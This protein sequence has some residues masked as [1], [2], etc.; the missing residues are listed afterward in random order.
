MLEIPK[1]DQFQTIE[2]VIR[3]EI[4]VKS[5][6]FIA[7]ALPIANLED[8]NDSL[9]II[10]QEFFDATHNCYAYRLGQ[11]A[12]IYKFS[13]DGEPNGSAGKPILYTISKFDFTNILVVV[14]RYY[15]GTKLGV[16]GLVRAYSDS[17][18]E[19]LKIAIPKIIFIS[20]NYK[21]KCSYQDVSLVKRLITDFAI[22]HNEQYTDVVEFDIEIPKSLCNYFENFIFEKSNGKIIAQKN[23]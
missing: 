12:D 7:T 23:I 19:S 18:E 6:K 3:T 11:F 22:K 14:T 17:T 4:K 10:K 20:T 21:I 13:D 9:N 2:D 5:S 8:A 16:G 15:G 1:E